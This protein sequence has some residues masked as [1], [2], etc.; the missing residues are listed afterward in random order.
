MADEAARK[1]QAKQKF[2]QDRAA[3]LQKAKQ[4]LDSI[5]SEVEEEQ[6]TTD[7]GD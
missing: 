1:E 2:L 7:K 5:D 3:L 4:R 6:W